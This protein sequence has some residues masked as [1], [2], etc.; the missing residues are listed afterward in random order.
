MTDIHRSEGEPHDRL[1]R[2]CGAML[3]ALDAHDERGG[4]RC[5]IFLQDGDD[6]GLVMHGYSDDAD[7]IVDIILHLRAILRS[8]GADLVVAPLGKG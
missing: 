7:A 8:K 6:G 1:T 5:V 2:L 4:E 3:D